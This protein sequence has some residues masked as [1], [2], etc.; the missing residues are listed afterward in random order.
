MVVFAG[1]YVGE[2]LPDD[3]EVRKVHVSNVHA[4][5]KGRQLCNVHVIGKGR[6]L[7]K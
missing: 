4:Y 3:S 6:Q 2:A 1:P 5:G 7:P